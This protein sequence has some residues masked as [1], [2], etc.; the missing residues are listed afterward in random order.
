M[1]MTPLAYAIATEIGRWPYKP[2]QVIFPMLTNWAIECY[3]RS[4]QQDK[5]LSA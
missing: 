2:D 3:L 1:N 4:I 5:A